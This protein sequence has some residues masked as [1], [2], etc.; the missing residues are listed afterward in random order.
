[1]IGALLKLVCDA[2]DPVC[3]DKTAVIFGKH[4]GFTVRLM[5]VVGKDGHVNEWIPDPTDAERIDK[6]IAARPNSG[7][8]SQA[9]ATQAVS[10]EP[11]EIP[12]QPDFNPAG[13][14]GL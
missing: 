8:P 2:F 14:P 9:T 1:M 5:P 13:V 10:A 11:P 3:Q 6:I 4:R 12:A 7:T